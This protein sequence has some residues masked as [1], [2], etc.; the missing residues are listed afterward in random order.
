[1]AQRLTRN[2]AFYEVLVKGRQ[3]SYRIA[4]SRGSGHSP[5]CKD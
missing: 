1:M 4:N 5:P 2:P 3:T